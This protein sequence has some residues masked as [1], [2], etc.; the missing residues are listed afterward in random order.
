MDHIDRKI[1]ALF[2]HDTRRI[3]DSIGAEVG[4]S[5]AAVQR[6][7]KRMRENG[8]IQGEIALLNARAVGVITCIALLTMA[9]RPRPSVYLD[10]FKRRMREMPEV[11][12]CYQVTGSSDLVIVVS[13][14]SMEHYAEFSRRW[15]ESN[16]D[17]ARYETLVVLDRVKVGLS[18]PVSIE[19]ISMTS[20]RT[21]RK[22]KGA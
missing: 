18:L 9:A 16:E 13:A 15:F 22:P 8:A 12:Q 19:E 17:I 5:A 2:Q 11:Q 1:L 14:S 20:P 4:L 6:R 7:V 10:R 3:A 21:R